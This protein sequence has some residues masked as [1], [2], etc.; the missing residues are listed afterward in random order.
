LNLHHVLMQLDI[1]N[2][3]LTPANSQPAVTQPGRSS[4]LPIYQT[5]AD[6]LHD[7]INK[8][9]LRAGDRMPSVRT[10]CSQ[11]G[12]S[13]GTATQAFRVLEMRMLVEA[14][15]KS[16]YFVRHALVQS[17]ARLPVVDSVQL[18]TPVSGMPDTTR[19]VREF[20]ELCGGPYVT[21]FA[22]AT[23]D[24]RLLP[25][26]KIQSLIA[27]INRRRGFN[28]SYPSHIGTLELRN[29]IARCVLTNGVQISADDIVATEGC[30][31][32]LSIALRSVAKPGDTIAV[33]SPTYFS[34]L[35][36]L[37]SLG[38]N[39]L[40][41]PTHPREGISIEALE[42]ATRERGRVQAIVVMPNFQNPLGSLMSDKRKQQLL[43]LAIERDI[44]IIEDDVY[45]DLHHEMP[46]PWPIKA[47]DRDGRV[48]LCSSFSKTIAPSLRV[49][50]LIAGRYRERAATIKYITSVAS[51][52]LQQ[53]VVAA[54]ISDG[55]Y[56][57]HLRKLRAA[58]KANT[59]R[60][61][62][63]M[64]EAFPEGCRVSMPRGGYILWVELPKTVDSRVLFRRAA[65]KHIAIAPG[66]VFSLTGRYNNYLRMHSGAVWDDQ[67]RDGLFQLGRLIR[68]NV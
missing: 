50:Y 32:A 66:A 5:I 57:H 43:A 33:E 47:W 49:G 68:E 1:S 31:E 58:L 2:Y 8:G 21:P 15:P 60:M 22:A 35:Q 9:T 65:D 37:E 56:Q 20:A 44:P 3:S 12:V 62:S 34:L 40:E 61:I 10:L 28:A 46:R 54:F 36:T 4:E 19:I 23:P 41:I 16:G 18:E 13:P 38:M 51:T 52:P 29:Q 26:A 27:T 64:S 17:L 6:Q 24:R 63:A 67:L 25:E 30:M 55:G 48:L 39:V 42:L 14:R 59:A 53:D 11:F 45:G 7:A